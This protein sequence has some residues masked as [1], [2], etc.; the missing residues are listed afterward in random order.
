MPAIH[1]HHTDLD[2]KIKPDLTY[3]LRFIPQR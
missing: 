1:G 2:P 3:A